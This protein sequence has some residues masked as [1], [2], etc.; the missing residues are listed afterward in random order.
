MLALSLITAAIAGK[1]S[2]AFHRVKTLITAYSGALFVPSDT[3]CFS[4]SAGSTPAVQDGV[5]GRINDLAGSGL[6]ASQAT[7][8]YKPILRKGAKNLYLNSATL[9]TQNNTVSAIPYT[10]QHTGTGTITFSGAYVGSLAGAGTITFTPSAGTLTSTVTGTVSN[11]MLEIG[12]T[13]SPYVATTSSPASNGI[14]LWWLDFDGTDDR[15]DLSAVPFQMAD[16][17]FVSVATKV[18]SASANN[19]LFSNTNTATGNANCPL[20]YLSNTSAYPNVLYSD[21]TPTNKYSFHT[22]SAIGQDKVISAKRLV[23]TNTQYFRING[24]IVD[25]DFQSFGSATL[26]QAKIGAWRTAVFLTGRIYG[27]ALGKDAITD[28]EL[29]T[30]ERYLGSL[31][32]VTI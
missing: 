5:V 14:G 29:L 12:P 19:T 21:D 26:D 6:Y 11:A 9:S 18:I 8:G 30:I 22:V 1:D 32:G 25:S 27:I 23:S 31:A 4:D 15:L 13:A 20:L 24:S 7:T 28:A 2:G 17:H 3:T 10:V 16:A